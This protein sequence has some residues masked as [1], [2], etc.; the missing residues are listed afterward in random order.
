MNTL[1]VS[2]STSDTFVKMAAIGKRNREKGEEIRL[3]ANSLELGEKLGSILLPVLIILSVSVSLVILLL[4][5]WYS[6]NLEQQEAHE[7][8]AYIRK[9]ERK[10]P[11]PN[12]TRKAE[13]H[14]SGVGDEHTGGACRDTCPERAFAEVV[15]IL[16]DNFG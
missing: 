15:G 9:Q 6:R 16:T 4:A 12:T 3:G 14:L 1:V 8:R 11:A 10:N 7:G 13:S 2:L 5:Q